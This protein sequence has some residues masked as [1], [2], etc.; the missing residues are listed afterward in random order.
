VTAVVVD[1]IAETPLWVALPGAE[2]LAERAAAAAVAAA[3]IA[4]LT[5]A[6]ISVML[7][8]D[9]RLRELN[10]EWRGQDKPTNVLSFPAVPSE[11]LATSPLLGDIAVAYETARRE[12]D[13]EGKALADHLVHLIIH[14][15]L[16]LLGHDHLDVAEAERME[17]LEI[18]VLAGLG[19]ADPYGDA[20]LDEAGPAIRMARTP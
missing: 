1:V 20:P 8:D 5:G 12:A 10:L 14:G 19:I 18:R 13:A 11:R 3:G 9:A 4:V 7:A 17:A 6:E 15:T 2:E 16:H